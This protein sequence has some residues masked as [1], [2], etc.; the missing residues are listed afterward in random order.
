[1]QQ[2]YTKQSLERLIRPFPQTIYSLQ[3]L[4]RANRLHNKPHAHLVR[5]ADKLG[6]VLCDYQSI[7]EELNNGN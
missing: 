6:D 4:A 7:M 5:L 1:M 3:V 2:L